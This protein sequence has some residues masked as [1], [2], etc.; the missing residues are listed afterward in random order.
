MGDNKE[1]KEKVAAVVAEAEQKKADI[2][3]TTQE[4]TAQAEEAAKKADEEFLKEKA[5]AQEK[6]SKKADAV[7]KAAE[8]AEKELEAQTAAKAKKLQQEAAAKAKSD[9]AV[10]IKQAEGKI[11]TEVKQKIQQEQVETKEDL[12]PIDK[13]IQKFKA[14]T[15]LVKSQT[16]EMI[17]HGNTHFTKGQQ[18]LLELTQKHSSELDDF[19][20]ESQ[21]ATVA[22]AE[23]P[24]NYPLITGL[25]FVNLLTAGFA[26]SYYRSTKQMR[27]FH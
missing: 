3:K 6:A 24:L 5:A 8:D 27:S 11:A 16:K 19:G 18:G 7:A 12:S 10:E 13:E 23:E 17:G 25:V 26:Y 9:A 1:A 2:E 21:V 4:K 22:S 20:K 15:K 14:K